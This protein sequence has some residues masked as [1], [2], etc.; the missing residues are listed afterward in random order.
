MT[1]CHKSDK[2]AIHTPSF[3]KNLYCGIHFV[4]TKTIVKL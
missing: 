3:L 1:N 2:N 4:F